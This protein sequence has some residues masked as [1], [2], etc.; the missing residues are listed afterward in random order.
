MF[1]LSY[2][3]FNA[4]D[5]NMIKKGDQVMSISAMDCSEAAL[6]PLNKDGITLKFLGCHPADPVATKFASLRISGAPCNAKPFAGC[7]V[8][9]G[10]AGTVI[11][12]KRPAFIVRFDG[13]H[14]VY[15]RMI[16]TSIVPLSKRPDRK[17]VV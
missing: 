3:R 14:S 7:G 8:Y 6:F 4:P 11:Y 9:H 12:G 10:D 2:F 1:D 15:H 16:D 5:A 13:Y 17:S